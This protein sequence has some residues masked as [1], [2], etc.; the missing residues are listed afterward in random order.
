MENKKEPLHCVI[1]G[2]NDGFRLVMRNTL[3]PVEFAYVICLE[4]I[5]KAKKR[6]E[7][8]QNDNN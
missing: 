6:A 1:C 7:E 5:N 3:M 2:R 8:T 4:C